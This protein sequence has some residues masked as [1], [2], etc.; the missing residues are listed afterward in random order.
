MKII[1]TGGA[2]FIGSCFV[3]KCLQKGYEVLNIDKLTY[4]GNLD[5]LRDIKSTQKY[6]F[7]KADIGDLEI[8]SRCLDSFDPDWIVNFAAETHVDRSIVDP[9]VFFNTNVLA[10]LNLLTTINTWYVKSKKPNFRFHH[11]STDEVFG[12]LEIDDKPFK[13][14]NQYCPNSPYSASKASSDHVVRS[15]HETFG[16]PTLISNCSNNYGPRQFPE[17]LIPLMILKAINGESL[18][19]YGTGM[20]IR[21]W[22]HVEDH[23]EAIFQILTFGKVGQ[24]YNIGGNCE[25]S[26]LYVVEKICEYL[27]M[28]V[29]KAHGGKYRDQIT[30]VKDRPGHD[31]RYAIDC[32]KIQ[33]ELGWYP[34]Y[35]FEE[36]IKETIH[37]YLQNDQWIQN[38]LTGQY[39]QW[40]DRNYVGR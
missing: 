25:R 29:P 6:N 12:S 27:D 37:W 17:K 34:K 26:N 40:L 2:G 38:V 20:N 23:C 24:T 10:T 14:T 33:S 15:F 21:D 32:S 30:F 5:N 31:K 11:I 22:L 13:E 35:T 4:S 19:I 8:I 39:R 16:L 18:P 9:I 28:L 3:L 1:V 7:V 36:G